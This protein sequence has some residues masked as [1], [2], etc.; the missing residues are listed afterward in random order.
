MTTRQ[1][2]LKKLVAVQEQ[3]KALHETRR[4]TLLAEAHAAEDKKRREGVEARNQ[5]ESLI[6][7]TEKSLKDYGDKVSEAD[8]TAIAAAIGFGSR[9]LI[10]L[11]VR[12]RRQGR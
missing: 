1:Q 2:R 8:R 10:N 12:H 5:A 3:L 7:S 4:A 6:H 9:A 11:W